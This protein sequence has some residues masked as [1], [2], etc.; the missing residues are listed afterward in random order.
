MPLRYQKH[1][2][3]RKKVGPYYY[4]LTTSLSL[5][6]QLICPIFLL[7]LNTESWVRK[8]PAGLFYPRG[9]PGFHI[10]SL[11]VPFDYNCFLSL[12]KISALK[13]Y[14]STYEVLLYLTKCVAA[15]QTIG[16]QQLSLEA[17][18]LGTL[19]FHILAEKFT[20]ESELMRWERG[21]Y[22]LSSM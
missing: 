20:G 17:C 13:M 9:M 5:L 14:C 6:Y 2:Y 10:I 22:L 16:Y 12:C 15:F 4:K 21:K 3:S 18:I 11:Q 1:I 7:Q 19:L 8:S